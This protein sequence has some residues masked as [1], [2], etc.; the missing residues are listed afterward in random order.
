MKHRWIWAW[1]LQ[2]AEMLAVS[3]LA[4]LSAGAGGALHGLMLW[5]A[6]PA[7]GLLTA[8]Q[9]VR[10]GLNNYLAWIAPAPCLYAANYLVWGY[11]PPAGSALLAAFLALVGA[12][13]G[14]VMNRRGDHRHKKRNTRS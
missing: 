13:A 9:A 8:C 6:V 2:I 1:A 5:V 4:A 10:R 3:L 12:A 7:A 11:S 14:E